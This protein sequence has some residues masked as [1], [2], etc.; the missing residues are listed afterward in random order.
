MATVVVPVW[1]PSPDLER[2][3]DSLLR[4]TDLSLHEVLVVGD[5]PLEPA[6]AEVVSRFAELSS[7]GVRLLERPARGGFPVAANAGLA[8]ARGDAVLLNSDTEVPGGW[9]ERLAE[10]A[11]RRPRTASATPFSNDATLC[12]LPAPFVAN[13]LPAGFT[14]ASFDRL[15]QERSARLSPTIPT[16]VGFCLYLVREALD[17]VGPLDEESFGV[18][19]GEEVDWCLRASERGFRHVLDDATFVWHRGGGSFGAEKVRRERQAERRD[20]AQGLT[21]RAQRCRA[22]VGRP[23]VSATRCRLMYDRSAISARA[24]QPVAAQPV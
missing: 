8:R 24:V 16:G 4:G 17:E 9:L 20:I 12:S 18:G 21:A 14:V 11:R 5:G 23:N 19:Y 3:L 22:A 10:A 6:P 7:G 13:D 1:G 15:V 2:C